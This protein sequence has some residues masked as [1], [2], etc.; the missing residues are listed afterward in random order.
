MNFYIG[1][2]LQYDLT[3][4]LFVGLEYRYY[5]PFIKTDDL[6]SYGKNRYMDFH[7]VSLLIGMRF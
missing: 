2:G 4:D 1:A 6:N 7:N 3:C 5:M